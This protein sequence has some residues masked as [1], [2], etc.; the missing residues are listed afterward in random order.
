MSK[1]SR[2]KTRKEKYAVQNE[3]RICKKDTKAAL[4]SVGLVDSRVNVVYHR[5]DV[6]DLNDEEAILLLM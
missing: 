6:A 3:P 5:P 2:R 1:K 4:P